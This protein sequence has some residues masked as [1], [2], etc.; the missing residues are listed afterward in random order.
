MPPVS[1]EQFVVVLGS[2]GMLGGV[3]LGLKRVHTEMVEVARVTAS[4]VRPSMRDS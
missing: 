3:A 4:M 1:G 2:L